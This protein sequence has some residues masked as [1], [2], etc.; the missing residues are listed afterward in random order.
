MATI[1]LF[2]IRIH[3]IK[4]K[5]GIIVVTLISFVQIIKKRNSFR[6]KFQHH[7]R[8]KMFAQNFAKSFKMC[9]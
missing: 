9:Y 1:V 6:K 8:E 4:T 2:T 3:S 7:G 5:V